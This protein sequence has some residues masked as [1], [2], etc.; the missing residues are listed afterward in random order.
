MT[1]VMETILI[2]SLDYEG[3]QH[4]GD[5]RVYKNVVP[6]QPH[7]RRLLAPDLVSQDSANDRDSR[8]ERTALVYGID[9]R[10]VEF[11]RGVACK[12]T[13]RAWAKKK[14]SP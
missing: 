9:N 5:H 3:N 13:A 6:L 11:A 7:H 4:E 12:S 10:E 1:L 14:T 8:Q 2:S